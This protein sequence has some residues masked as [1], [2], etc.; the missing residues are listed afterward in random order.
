[1]S[2]FLKKLF[3]DSWGLFGHSYHTSRLSG[4]SVGRTGVRE[5][6]IVVVASNQPYLGL[7]D[8]YV[9]WE[10]GS[11]HSI[12]KKKSTVILWLPTFYSRSHPYTQGNRFPFFLVN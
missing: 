7:M 2:A 9:V 11:L 10:K 4:G 3:G 8:T 5:E 12:L 1:M 6:R